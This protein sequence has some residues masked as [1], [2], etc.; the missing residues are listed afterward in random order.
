MTVKE[1]EV[2][3]AAM[4][5]AHHGVGA[6]ESS[7]ETGTK[8]RI[9]TATTATVAIVIQIDELRRFHDHRSPAHV[10]HASA[11]A[12]SP[13]IIVTIRI[14]P[15]VIRAKPTIVASIVAGDA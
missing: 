1:Q 7:K 10:S 15:I 6:M 9:R 2:G 11:M 12:V 13:A 14:R 4:M 8:R 5:V 3:H